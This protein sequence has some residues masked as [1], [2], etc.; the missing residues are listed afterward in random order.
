MTIEFDPVSVRESEC[1]PNDEQ[2]MKPIEMKKF[3]VAFGKCV[4]F[5]MLNVELIVRSAAR[6][7]CKSSV[8]NQTDSNA[9]MGKFSWENQYRAVMPLFDHLKLYA[10]RF[11]HSLQIEIIRKAT[12]RGNNTKTKLEQLPLVS[13]PFSK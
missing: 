9:M 8:A 11:F 10:C 3:C 7:K 5:I 2:K 12:G 6:V 4:H 13:Y 1:A